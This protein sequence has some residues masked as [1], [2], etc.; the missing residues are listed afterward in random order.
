MWATLVN[1]P[2]DV[3]QE[4]QE[5]SRS[6]SE[7]SRRGPAAKTSCDGR[8]HISPAPYHP[9]LNG[10]LCARMK[11][12]LCLAMASLVAMQPPPPGRGRGRGT[13]GTRLD[14]SS[15][16][17][18]GLFNQRLTNLPRFCSQPNEVPFSLSRE[19]GMERGRRR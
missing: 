17:L 2:S 13:S 9:D 7:S 18:L 14:P 1:A 19:K 3:F 12:L 5:P 6:G 8:V 11:A 4:P 10:Q 16:V 15:G